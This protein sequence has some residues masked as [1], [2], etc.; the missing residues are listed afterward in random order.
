MKRERMTVTIDKDTLEELC[1][2]VVGESV[3]DE[4]DRTWHV[5]SN[6][7][8]DTSRWTVNYHLVIRQTGSD[9]FFGFRYEKAAGESNVDF[10]GEFN[11]EIMVL[12]VF[13][14]QVTTTVYE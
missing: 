6:K 10:W 3:D 12:Q 11:D 2:C 14:K 5:E 8:L 13:P 4:A 9:N 7:I 1:T